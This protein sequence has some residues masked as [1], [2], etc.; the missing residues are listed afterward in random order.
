MSMIGQK[1]PE[2]TAVAYVNGEQKTVSSKDYAGKWHVLYWYP[3]RL[4]VRMPDRDQGLSREESRVQRRRRLADR[5]QHRLVLQP[6]G[7]VRRPQHLPAADHASGDRRHQSRRDPR[8]RR[9]QGRRRRRVPRD[10]DRRRQRHRPLGGD[11]RPERRSQPDRGAAHGTSA[12]E[13]W[14]LRRR[15]EEGRPLRRLTFGRRRGARRR[16]ASR[17]PT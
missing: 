14:P 3:A 11:Q 6:Q 12:P 8:L 15:L 2:W 4:H 7:V 1:E 5:R 10:G 16:D 13:R 9:A 17:S